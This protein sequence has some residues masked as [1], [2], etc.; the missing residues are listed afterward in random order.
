MQH[1]FAF[2]KRAYFDHQQNHIWNEGGIQCFAEALMFTFCSFPQVLLWD[3]V[4]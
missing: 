4:Q 1:L 2:G 3:G